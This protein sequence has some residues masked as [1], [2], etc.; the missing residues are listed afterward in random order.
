MTEHLKR[1]IFLALGGL[2]FIIGLIGVLVPILPTTPFMILSAACFAE[3]SPRFHKLLLN[4]RWF[5]EDLRRWERNKTMKRE[6]K[7]RATVVIV[8]SFILS[9]S[10]LWGKTVWQLVLVCIALLLLYF[11]WRIA[12]HVPQE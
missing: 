7:K 1:T 2:F 10:L 6:T 9:I 11:L 8:V 4:N 12:E 3:S 5:G